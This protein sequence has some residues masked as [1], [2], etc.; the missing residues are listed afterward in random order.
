MIREFSTRKA[1]SSRRP[2][3]TAALFGMTEEAAREFEYQS[4]N[5]MD[6]VKAWTDSKGC[7]CDP[8]TQVFSMRRWNAQ[9]FIV[10][11]NSRPLSL[12]VMGIK[13]GLTDADDPRAQAYLESLP[14]AEAQA[15]DRKLDQSRRYS[16]KVPVWCRCQVKARPF[17]ALPSAKDWDGPR[18][19]RP[20]S[21]VPF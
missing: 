5:N 2:P 14:Q 20:E 12:R 16:A 6:A 18:E 17:T 15:L 8:Y 3:T 9:G 1:R 7:H 11:R 4:D 19:A 13:K 10:N 21:E